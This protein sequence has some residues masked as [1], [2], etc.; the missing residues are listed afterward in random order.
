ML[1]FVMTRFPGQLTEGILLSMNQDSMRVVLRGAGDTVEL[2]RVRGRWL[3]ENDQP[4]DFEVLLTDSHADVN[5]YE[6]TAP[7]VMAAGC[8]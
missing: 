3:E 1:N 6:E 8:A 2:R 7:R 4:V 5:P